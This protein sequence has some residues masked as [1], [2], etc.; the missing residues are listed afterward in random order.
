MLYRSLALSLTIG[1]TMWL[2][3][4]AAVHFVTSPAPLLAAAIPLAP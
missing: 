2:L 1:C 4:F 3:L